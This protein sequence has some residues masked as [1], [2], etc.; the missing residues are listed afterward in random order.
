VGHSERAAGESKY[1]FWKLINLQFNLL[2]CMTTFPLRIL[3]Y[4]G[5]LSGMAGFL[6]GLYIFARRFI[7]ED[8]DSWGQFGIFTLFA[9]LF[10]FVGIQMFGIGLIGEYI[11]RIYTDVRAR[12]AFFID[13]VLG[14]KDQ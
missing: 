13:R 1:S 11:G 4:F 9:V 8:G 6:L 12:P 10:I 5:I 2:T 3:T 7:M 14:R